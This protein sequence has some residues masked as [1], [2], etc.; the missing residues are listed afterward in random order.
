MPEPVGAAINTFFPDWIAGHASACAGVGPEN[1]R[2][3]QLATAG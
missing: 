2:S 1:V 3:N